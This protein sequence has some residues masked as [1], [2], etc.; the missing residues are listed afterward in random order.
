MKKLPLL[1]LLIALALAPLPVSAMMEPKKS[2]EE[3]KS[4][5]T[6]PHEETLK[7][8]KDEETKALIE[9][10]NKA[11]NPNSFKV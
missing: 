11:G 7:Y 9:E 5:T 6:N 2:G 8:T 1:L 3:K 10:H 4:E